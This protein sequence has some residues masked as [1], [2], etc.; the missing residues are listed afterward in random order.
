MSLRSDFSALCGDAMH[1]RYLI[2][3][4]YS[5]VPSVVLSRLSSAFSQ[6][7]TVSMKLFVKGTSADG[8]VLFHALNRYWRRDDS[9]YPKTLPPDDIVVYVRIPNIIL[10]TGD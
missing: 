7:N 9:L 4:F 8:F 5:G 2:A 10:Y 3:V 1:G 6:Y